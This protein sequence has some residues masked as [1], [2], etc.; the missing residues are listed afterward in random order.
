MKKIIALSV[1][2]VFS[3]CA[4]RA[5]YVELRTN[6]CDLRYMM[7]QL[8][9]AVA[10]NHAVI[11]NVVCEKPVKQE[12]PIVQQTQCDKSVER[13]VNRE[14]FVR[15]T[16]QTYRPVVHYEPLDTYTTMRAVCDDTDC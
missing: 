7:T 16:V 14:Y 3:V 4:A 5:D 13:V 10:K 2:G 1:I 6:H 12:Q 15:E 9:R 8:N 11:T